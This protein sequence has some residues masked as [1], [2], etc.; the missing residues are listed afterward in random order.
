MQNNL[1][2][3]STLEWLDLYD[4]ML[5]EFPLNPTHLLT[6][7]KLDVAENYVD[8]EEALDYV[9]FVTLEV[10]KQDRRWGREGRLCVDHGRGARPTQ[11]KQRQLIEVDLPSIVTT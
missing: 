2:G 3:L 10:N 7:K 5:E 8:L 11:L 4:N 6:L 1:A 9:S